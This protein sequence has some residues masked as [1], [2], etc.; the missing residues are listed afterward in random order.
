MKH[1]FKALCFFVLIVASSAI[2]SDLKMPFGLPQLPEARLLVSDAYESGASER[3][4]FVAR[5][6]TKMALGDAIA[7]YQ[8]ALEEAGFKISLP[9]NTGNK[10]SFSGKRESDRIRVSA[11]TDGGWA[12][13]GENELTIVA[14]YNKQQ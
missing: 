4:E 6:G 3:E 5:F 9:N 2:A 1:T 13:A 7:F 8:S 12:D 10:I 14:N 11:R